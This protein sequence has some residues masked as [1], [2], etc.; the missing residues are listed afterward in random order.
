MENTALYES[1]RTGNFSVAATKKLLADAARPNLEATGMLLIRIGRTYFS[2]SAR[3]Q[4]VPTQECHR[5]TLAF[6]F[7]LLFIIKDKTVDVLITQY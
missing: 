6:T 3:S 4:L 2:L 7:L 5:A 1:A